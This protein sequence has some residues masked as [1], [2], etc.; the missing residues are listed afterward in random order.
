MPTKRRKIAPLR[1]PGITEAAIECWRKG[2][3]WG[4]HHE[5]GL[6]LWQMPS[7][8]DDPPDEPWKVQP[9]PH[10]RR[11]PDPAVLKAQLIEVAGPP[12]RRWHFR[13]SRHAD[14]KTPTTTTED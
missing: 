8:L 1:V 5:L 11:W 4:L 13:G 3:Y 14:K 10:G 9:L 7:W 6:Q 12:P 2:D